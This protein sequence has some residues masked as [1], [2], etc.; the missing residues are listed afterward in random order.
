MRVE[1]GEIDHCCQHVTLV[2]GWI[3]ACGF[4]HVGWVRHTS[5]RDVHS[6]DIV[7]VVMAQCFRDPL[8][9][10]HPLDVDGEL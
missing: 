8:V 10:L 1:F 6:R 5:A 2:D 9:F 4:Q 3:D 7:A